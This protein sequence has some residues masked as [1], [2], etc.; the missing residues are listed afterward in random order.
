MT[1]GMLS[2]GLG[3]TPGTSQQSPDGYSGSYPTPTSGQPTPGALAAAARAVQDLSNVNNDE[4]SQ[5]AQQFASFFQPGMQSIDWNN[6]DNFI[7][8][9][10]GDPDP[11]VADL[12]NL[13]VN[14]GNDQALQNMV[15]STNMDLPT[16][17]GDLNTNLF[18]NGGFLGTNQPM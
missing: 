9:A 13:N 15:E 5:T 4:M 12:A 3:Q 1:L 14:W 7:V 10:N 17:P 16:Q 8:P 2:T 18:A 6:I 11:S